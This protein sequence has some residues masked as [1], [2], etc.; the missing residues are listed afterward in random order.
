MNY[1]IVAVIVLFGL[2]LVASIYYGIKDGKANMTKD[3]TT[4]LRDKIALVVLP[5]LLSQCSHLEYQELTDLAYNIADI[6]LTSRNKQ[7]K[8]L[9]II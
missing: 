3:Y 4:E 8:L 1:F 5:V 9:I 7:E 2:I 6:M